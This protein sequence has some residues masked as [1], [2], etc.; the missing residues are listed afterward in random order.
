MIK[1]TPAED[2]IYGA[3]HEAPEQMIFTKL[4]DPLPRSLPRTAE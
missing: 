2:R 3:P 4:G 1:I